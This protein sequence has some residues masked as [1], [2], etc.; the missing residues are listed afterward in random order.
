LN[1]LPKVSKK[2]GINRLL[3]WIIKNKLSITKSIK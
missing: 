3:D 2:D 1:W